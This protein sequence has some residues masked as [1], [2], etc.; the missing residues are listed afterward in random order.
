MLYNTYKRRLFYT[1]D[2]L[3][4]TIAAFTGKRLSQWIY[5][6]CLRVCTHPFRASSRMYPS[7]IQRIYAYLSGDIRIRIHLLIVRASRHPS[8][9][10]LRAHQRKTLASIRALFESL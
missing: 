9:Y 10:P 5:H 2:N 7:Y 6:L 8:S 3:R 1:F 4:I